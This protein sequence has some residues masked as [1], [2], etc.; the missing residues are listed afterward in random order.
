VLPTLRLFYEHSP[1]GHRHPRRAVGE[2][3]KRSV[4]AVELDAVG[5]ALLVDYRPA[6]TIGQGIRDRSSS[7]K[8]LSS[9]LSR[10][11]QAFRQATSSLRTGTGGVKGIGVWPKKPTGSHCL[12]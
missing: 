5:I 8:G 7:T 9:R 3:H 6:S 4:S 11:L 2:D 1:V 12:C 10:L